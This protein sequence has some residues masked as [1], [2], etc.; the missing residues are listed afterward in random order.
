[1]KKIWP[2]LVLIF[3]AGL[4]LVGYKFFGPGA[5][6]Q[7]DMSG[8]KET[9]LCNVD[10]HTCGAV[11]R[12]ADSGTLKVTVKSAGKGVSGLEVDLG[13]RPGA[14]NYYI[15]LTDV[16]GVA[17]LTG[18]P[19][20]KYYIYFNGFNFPKEYGDSPTEK[21]SVVSGQTTEVVINIGASNQ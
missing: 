7:P 21:V 9:Q 2:V 14:P 5:G 1:M 12:T 15:R 10:S 8:A 17:V 3:L 4:G 6:N 13:A 11:Q 20:G 19:A 16:N 18:I